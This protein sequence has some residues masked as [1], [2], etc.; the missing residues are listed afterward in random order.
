VKH[1]A[2][3]PHPKCRPP[4]SHDKTLRLRD[5]GRWV[6][7]NGDAGLAFI[8]A[9]DETGDA[10]TIWVANCY[11]KTYLDCP[12]SKAFARATALGFG[13]ASVVGVRAARKRVTRKRPRPRGKK[14]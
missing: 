12:V 5:D 1:V 6:H 8:R 7:D 2:K 14:R 3:K 9:A 13:T 4:R 10:A 11:C